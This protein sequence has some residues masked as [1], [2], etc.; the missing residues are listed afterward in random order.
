MYLS[1]AMNRFQCLLAAISVGSLYFIFHSKK[2]QKPKNFY[3]SKR[4]RR[5]RYK[6]I[7]TRG[8]KCEACGAEGDDIQIHVDHI[9]PRHKYPYRALDETNLQILC[10]DCNMGKGVWDET[11][12]RR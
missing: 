5:L 1:S 11:D 4:W 12:W 8:R 6:V 2:N 9:K 3:R 7:K 10:L